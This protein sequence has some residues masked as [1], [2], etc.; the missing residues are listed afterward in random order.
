MSFEGKENKD[1]GAWGSED[2]EAYDRELERLASASAEA[3]ADRMKSADAD[4][5][6]LIRLA[7]DAEEFLRNRGFDISTPAGCKAAEQW[8]SVARVE[9]AFWEDNE[10]VTNAADWY[11]GEARLEGMMK[12]V[13]SRI[14]KY[15]GGNT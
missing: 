8:L 15:F 11:L 14:E 3:L 7:G 1:P 10:P 13:R 5:P 12:I 9:D 4:D 2:R 6:L